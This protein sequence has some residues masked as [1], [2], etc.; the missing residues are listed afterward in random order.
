MR[1][2]SIDRAPDMWTPVRTLNAVRNVATPRTFRRGAAQLTSLHAVT[3]A[4]TE[5][6]PRFHSLEM[7]NKRR[8]LLER[9]GLLTYKRG[10]ISWFTNDGKQL[11]ATVLEV[12]LCEVLQNK[13]LSLD[14]YY[15]VQLGQ[16]TKLKNVTAQ[17]LK[18]CQKAGVSPKKHIAEFRVRDASGLIPEG[19]EVTADYFAVGQ[20]VDCQSIS[21]GKGFAG[22]MKRHGFAG[23]RAT[24]GVS[25]A[26]RSAGSMGATQD[27]GRVLPGKKMAGHMGVN[28]RTVLNNEV[29][30]TDGAHGILV[31]KGQVAGP[32]GCVVKV[33]DAKRLYGKSEDGSR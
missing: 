15:A 11:A 26:H 2:P 29:L 30:Y 6:P 25:K 22:V 16:G 12:D 31:V 20:K 23:L 18:H 33:A 10:M 7:A 14:G 19:T 3:S 8:Q 5:P 17:L 28:L 32:R 21:K 9:P 4:K 13:T 1:T 27:P 24:H